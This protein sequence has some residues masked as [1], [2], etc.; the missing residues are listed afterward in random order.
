VYATLLFWLLILVAAAQP[1]FA[2]HVMGGALPQTFLQGLLSGLGHPIIGI[3]HLAA[4]VAVG[5]LAARE[6]GSVLLVIGFVVANGLGAAAHLHLGAVPAGEILAALSV[7]ALGVV[8]VAGRPLSHPVLIGLFVVSGFLH[9]YALG[10]SIVGAEPQPL[11]AY[12]A[13]LAIIQSAIGIGAMLALPRLAHLPLA[14]APARVLGAGIFVVGII[15]T[16]QQVFS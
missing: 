4:I 6:P 3:D 13:G 7:M 12:F 15:V 16:V 10:E 5:C 8:L 1:A 14:F 2:H 9:G 11:A